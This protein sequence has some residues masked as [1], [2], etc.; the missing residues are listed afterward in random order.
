MTCIFCQR[1]IANKGSLAKHQKCCKLNPERVK[2]T[3]SPRAGRQ[4]GCDTWNKGLTKNEHKS[5]ARPEREGIRFGAS[6]NGHTEETKQKLSKIAKQRNLG[7]YVKGSGCGKKGW[8]KGIFCDSSWEL[9]FVIYCFDHNISI[10]RN[11]QKR[12]YTWNNKQKN[13]IPDFIV[14]GEL[15]EIKGWCT[16]EWKAKQTANPDIKVMYEN[17]LAEAFKYVQS[18]YG[19]QFTLLYES[20]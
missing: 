16:P 17:D 5:L 6:L 18:K 19:K 14:E 10:K 20:V 8:Y 7:G 12:Q 15:I 1:I 2:Y 9:A 11:T 3:R 13:Y 4:K